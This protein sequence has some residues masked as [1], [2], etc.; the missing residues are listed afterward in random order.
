MAVINKV[1]QI[2]RCAETGGW[3]TIASG[4]LNSGAVK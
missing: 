2:I 4:L 1:A 3:G